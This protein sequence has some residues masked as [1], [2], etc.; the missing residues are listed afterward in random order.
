MENGSLI[1]GG[2][3]PFQL[4]LG[5]KMPGG[6]IDLIKGLNDIAGYQYSSVRVKKN[7][8]DWKG[9]IQ[10][11]A[12][13]DETTLG[14][15]KNIF[16]NGNFE[17]KPEP[18]KHFPTGIHTVW[19]SDRTFNAAALRCSNKYVVA[20][21]FATPILIYRFFREFVKLPDFFP[22]IDGGIVKSISEPILFETYHPHI[23]KEELTLNASMMWAMGFELGKEFMR[24]TKRRFILAEFLSILCTRMII[25]HEVAHIISG[26]T[27]YIFKNKDTILT[28]L[29]GVDNISFSINDTKVRKLWEVEA[30]I[31]SIYILTFCEHLNNLQ[32]KYSNYFEALSIPNTKENF[33][34]VYSLCINILFILFGNIQEKTNSTEIH[35]HFYSRLKIIMDSFYFSIYPEWDEKSFNDFKCNYWYKYKSSIQSALDSVPYKSKSKISDIDTYWNEA[36]V[37]SQELATHRCKW[38]DFSFFN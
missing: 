16:S 8:F 18:Q 19:L 6:W 34:G 4:E 21:N 7:G 35:P 11:S 1:I 33:I 23:I 26:H 28:E 24:I 3:T 25:S 37:L 12:H 15:L 22:D 5:A 9:T 14:E 13:I 17:V 10:N 32:N 38:S 20:I 31:N 29:N 27:D 36:N 30:D 2:K